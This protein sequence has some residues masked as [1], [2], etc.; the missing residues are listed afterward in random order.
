[1]KMPSSNY[2]TTK[3]RQAISALSTAAVFLIDLDPGVGVRTTG[4]RHW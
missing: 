3:T 4:A 1:M 2:D